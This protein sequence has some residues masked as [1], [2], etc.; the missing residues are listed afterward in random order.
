MQMLQASMKALQMRLEFP[1]SSLSSLA[2]AQFLSFLVFGCIWAT[3]MKKK[4][5]NHLL[6]LA[7]CISGITAI[8]MGCVSSYPLVMA[9]TILNAC[10]TAATI[11]VSIN[12]LKN[13]FSSNPILFQG[14][15]WAV[16]CFGRFSSAILTSHFS[17]KSLYGQYAWRLLYIIL[18]YVWLIMSVPVCYRMVKADGRDTQSKAHADEQENETFWLS[19]VVKYTSDISFVVIPE[20]AL[21]LEQSDFPDD[22]VIRGLVV[23]HMGSIIGAFLGGFTTDVLH[24]ILQNKSSIVFAVGVSMAFLHISAM[25]ACLWWPLI[26]LTF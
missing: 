18:G 23:V 3:L 13:R 7:M 25:I 12:I 2:S 22:V 9:L 1:P 21:Y 8:L 14:S 10:G 11:P 24:H 19:V 15:W 20:L 4:K 5:C 26:G 17:T 6:S 16:Y